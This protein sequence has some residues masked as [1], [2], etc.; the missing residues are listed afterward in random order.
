MVGV[1]KES[2]WRRLLALLVWLKDL[3]RLAYS[4]YR[5]DAKR[6]NGPEWSILYVSDSTTNSEAEL[7]YLLFDEKPS[8]LWLGRHF[9]WKLKDVIRRYGTPDCLVVLDLNRL[10]K[11]S[12]QAKLKIRIAPWLRTFMDVSG[13]LD[14]T[15]QRMTRERRKNIRKLIVQRYE[16]AISQDPA[17]LEIFHDRLYLPHA[18]R[19]F[20]ER[21]IIHSIDIPRDASA[22]R[23][24]LFTVRK[25]GNLLAACLGRF[26]RY[27]NTFSAI[28]LGE[29]QK[30]EFSDRE[31][32]VEALYWH[33]I[34]W[35]HANHFNLVDFGRT[36]ARLNDGVFEFKRRWGMR[37]CKDIAGYAM[38]T[39]L[40]SDLPVP[41]IRRLNQLA[42]IAE[43]G[44][45]NRG[46]ILVSRQAPIEEKERLRLKKVA[47]QAGLDGLLEISM[48][49]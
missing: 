14:A 44:Q 2:I 7:Q 29:D 5:M 47:C 43:T 26:R 6:W 35:A 27:A 48:P 45:E 11:T 41:L 8:E 21:A 32:A 28:D 15:L 12:F 46:L 1:R 36:R 17:D 3:G 34:T 10:I 23:Q 4:G 20:G 13:T 24:M 30:S 16:F 33:I 25:H 31:N 49:D 37:F 22:K 40:A 39:F 19:R 18:N 38:W 9:T 42:F